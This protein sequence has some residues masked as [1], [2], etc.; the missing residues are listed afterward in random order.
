MLEIEKVEPKKLEILH[1]FT[2][3][4][5]E[6]GQDY[7]PSSLCSMQALIDRYRRERRYTHS[8]LK[9]RE[10]ASSKAIL[11]GKAR[12]IREDRRRRRPNNSLVLSS[13]KRSCLVLSS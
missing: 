4:K 3:L 8:V 11:E 13:N 5:K 12:V 6:D 2:Q 9:S 7:E 10:F 1:F